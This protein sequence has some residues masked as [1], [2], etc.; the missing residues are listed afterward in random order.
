MDETGPNGEGD[1]LRGAENRDTG[2]GL[3]TG[4]TETARRAPRA[5][6]VVGAHDRRRS[7]IRPLEWAEFDRKER[8]GGRYDVFFGHEYLPRGLD[9]CIVSYVMLLK[10]LNS[11]RGCSPPQPISS[12]VYIMMLEAMNG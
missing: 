5:A 11:G 1:S 10:A 4:L 2:G 6:G 8:T 12:A 3:T 7:V 9:P